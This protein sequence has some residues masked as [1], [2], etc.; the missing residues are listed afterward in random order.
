MALTSLNLREAASP[1]SVPI[2]RTN[3]K[4]G[5]SQYSSGNPAGTLGR[6]E[7]TAAACNGPPYEAA[8]PFYK[9]DPVHPEQ[10]QE[11]FEKLYSWHLVLY[12]FNFGVGTDDDK[13]PSGHL[14]T[15]IRLKFKYK[16][17][18]PNQVL[19]TIGQLTLDSATRVG[20]SFGDTS[21]P[22]GSTAETQFSHGEDGD[23]WGRVWTADEIRNDDLGVIIQ[24]ANTNDEELAV[25]ASIKDVELT[26]WHHAP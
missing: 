19:T 24:V 16:P 10:N 12:K 2:T 26:V 4:F 8:L 3:L 11:N 13:I 25:R 17:S 1:A 18:L 23:L 21:H 14:I 15:G 22:W 5:Q 9:Y 7:W 6:T 20:H